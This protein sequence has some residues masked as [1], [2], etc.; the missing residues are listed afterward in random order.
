MNIIPVTR[1]RLGTRFREIATAREIRTGEVLDAATILELQGR[2]FDRIAA[3]DAGD[4]I[5]PEE[6]EKALSQIRGSRPQT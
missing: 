3:R 4:V 2:F 6:F 5:T 1:M